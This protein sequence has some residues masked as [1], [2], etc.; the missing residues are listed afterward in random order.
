[1]VQVFRRLL[2]KNIEPTAISQQLDAM[3]G[4]SVRLQQLVPGL[5]FQLLLAGFQQDH[6][7][8]RIKSK[9]DIRELLV[10]KRAVS[11][12]PSEKRTQLFRVDSAGA[13][14][15][16]ALHATLRPNGMPIRPDGE[17]ELRL[18]G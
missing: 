18:A 12:E 4:L 17:N 16:A 11:F 7:E 2:P 14:G 5:H 3:I 6:S 10:S 15:W 9:I 1:I 13:I 8:L